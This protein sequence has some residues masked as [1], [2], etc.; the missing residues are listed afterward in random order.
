MSINELFVTTNSTTTHNTRG[1]SGTA[2]LTQLASS[3]ADNILR[4]MEANIE[5][6]RPRI[7]QSSVDGKALDELI[8]EL[9][10]IDPDKANFLTELDEATIEGILKSQ[11]SKRSRAKSK[12][13]TLDNY[14]NLLTAA[15][16][17]NIVR[18]TIGK[19]K[20][21][22]GARTGGG[23]VDYTGAQLE[24]FAADQ[25]ALKREIRNIQSKKSIMKSKADF[26]ESDER[27]INL[28]KAEQQ[29]KDLRIGTTTQV[30]EVDKTKDELAN[31]LGDVDITKLKSAEAHEL[32]ENI[33]NMLKG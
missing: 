28:L 26:D 6:Y 25:V 7:Q 13:M 24:A 32:L 19:P 1:L 20:T 23:T 3:I 12:H 16:A 9:G 18:I 22:G 30:V 29:L 15:I 31:M 17:E 27:W 10:E 8:D 21:H 11:Q 33:Q 5:E 4:A 2:E 14:R